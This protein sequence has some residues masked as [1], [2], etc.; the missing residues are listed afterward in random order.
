MGFDFQSLEFL[1]LVVEMNRVRFL[2]LIL[3]VFS[4]ASCASD[5]PGKPVVDGVNEVGR[6]AHSVNS[7]RSF[8]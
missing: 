6:F 2:L 4:L 5:Y 3:G 8:F 7:I 1:F